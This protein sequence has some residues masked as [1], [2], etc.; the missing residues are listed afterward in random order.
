[1]DFPGHVPAA[2]RSHIEAILEGEEGRGIPG[3]LQLLENAEHKLD[4]V[5]ESL[6]RKA[7]CGEFEYLDGLR[8]QRMEALEHRDSLLGDVRCLQRLVHDSRMR[9]AF[10]LLASAVKS[11]EQQ[12]S[13]IHAAWGARIDFSKHRDRLKKAAALTSQIANSAEELAKLLSQFADTGVGGPSEF[14]SIAELL[15]Q[16]DNHEMDNH[17]LHMWR[18]M[19]KHILGDRPEWDVPALEPVDL[20]GVDLHAMLQTIDAPGDDIAKISEQEKVRNF[21]RY[22]WGTAPDFSALL[23]TMSNAAQSFKPRESGMI[24]AAIDSRQHNQKTEYLRAFWNLLANTY[25]FEPTNQVMQA[26]AIVASIV[27]DLPDVDVTYD[28]VRKTLSR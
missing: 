21:L 7:I 1:M 16:T 10:E 14:F 17:N 4:A 24:G 8:L 20:K 9:E 18:S 19:R 2:V 6:E 22:A 26:M 11:D 23:R 27:L 3:Y 13:F 15:R 25:C 12:R 28:D 5:S